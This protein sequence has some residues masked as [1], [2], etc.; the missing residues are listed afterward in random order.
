MNN[1]NGMAR[2]TII[3]IMIILVMLA[4]IFLNQNSTEQEKVENEVA[5]TLNVQFEGADE[6][7]VTDDVVVVDSNTNSTS[8]NSSSKIPEATMK[9]NK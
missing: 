8:I 4:F 7:D 6:N 9:R 2:I 3:I 5:G 1:E